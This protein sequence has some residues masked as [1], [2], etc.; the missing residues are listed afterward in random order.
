MTLLKIQNSYG[1]YDFKILTVQT[2]FI[3]HEFNANHL[4]PHIFYYGYPSSEGSGVYGDES[5][6]TNLFI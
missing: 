4:T 5:K 6:Y 3:A 2:L 1:I